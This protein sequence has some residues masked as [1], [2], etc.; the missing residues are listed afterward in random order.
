M[1]LSFFMFLKFG[2][3]HIDVDRYLEASTARIT[4]LKIFWRIDIGGVDNVEVGAT[5][6]PASVVREVVDGER[7]AVAFQAALNPVLERDEAAKLLLRTA[8][9]DN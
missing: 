3:G 6:R 8:H 1:S 9:C 4:S 7:V 2:K 5:R